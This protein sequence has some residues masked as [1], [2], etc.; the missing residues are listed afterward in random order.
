MRVTIGLRCIHRPL[1]VTYRGG[2]GYQIWIGQGCAAG[3]SGPIPMFKCNFF[4]KKLP[5]FRDFSEKRYP[6]LAIFS[7]FSGVRYFENQTHSYGFFHE[8]WDPCL[9][10]Y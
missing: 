6:F 3:S 5:M 1:F 7:Q 10:I 8:K 2:G 4:L 9:G